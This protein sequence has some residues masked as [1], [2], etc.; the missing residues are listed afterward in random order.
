MGELEDDESERGKR[1]M[2]FG[3]E[4]TNPHFISLFVCLN[5]FHR[6]RND[7]TLTLLW[8]TRA[9][10]AAGPGQ[11]QPLPPSLISTIHSQT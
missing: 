8:C 9:L 4:P 11:E 7:M 5:K 2:C 3:L 10:S 1:E 6:N